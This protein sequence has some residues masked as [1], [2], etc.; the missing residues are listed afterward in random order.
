MFE[1]EI[2]SCVLLI[3]NHMVFLVQ[4]WNKFELVSFQRAQIALAL[5]ARAILNSLKTHSFKIYSKLHSK[6][7]DFL[8]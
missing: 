3:G 2:F 7:Y 1:A 6:P 4:F 5:R 8:Y